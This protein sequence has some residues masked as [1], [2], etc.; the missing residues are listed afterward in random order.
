MNLASFAFIDVLEQKLGSTQISSYT[1]LGKKLPLIFT[2]FSLVG[3][4]LI[5]LPPTAGFVGKLLVFSSIFEI[6]QSSGDQ[7]FLWLLIV[8]ALTSVISLF[9]YFKIP[10]YSFLKANK[11]DEAVISGDSK[12]SI[13]LVIGVVLTVLVVLFGIFPTLIINHLF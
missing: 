5:G 11:E 2:C 7:I 9:Y 10:L 12:I 8:G 6:Y 1:G 3:I 13:M 4:S